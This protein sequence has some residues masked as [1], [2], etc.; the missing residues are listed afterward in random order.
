MSR[1]DALPPP[2]LLA[3]RTFRRAWMAGALA[4]TMRWLEMMIVAVFVFRLSGSPLQVALVLFLRML[5]SFLFGALTGALSER[6]NR[7]WLLA[8]ALTLL[9]ALSMGLGVLV[10]ADLIAVWHVAVGVFVNG[11]FWSMDHSVRRTL[12]GELAGPDWVGRAIALD[13]STASATR[14]AGP[15]LGGVLLD[16]V[17][18]GGAYFVGAALFAASALLMA[19][20]HYARPAV[21]GQGGNLLTN[22]RAGLAYILSSRVISGTLV[23]TLLMNFFGFPYAGMLPVIAQQEMGAGDVRTGMLMSAEGAGAFVSAV[24]MAWRL[25]SRDYT[26]VYFWGSALFLTSILL[27]ANSGSFSLALPLLLLGGFGFGG[28]GAMQSTI[29]LFTAEP[30]FRA[31][32]MGVVSVC[33]GAGAPLGILHVGM[34]ADRFGAP[35]A[36]TITAVEGLVALAVAGWLWPELRRPLIPRS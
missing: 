14:A 34:M 1:E 26:R 27:F 8:G 20:L 32:A 11:M 29:I 21:G 36:V 31:R 25:R 9:S 17:G 3:N 7:K 5:P 2:S 18:M 13:S 16:V 10:L 15:L 28:F 4:Q 24:L 23:V 30:G 12:L 35:A 19:S 6:F 22:I 33:I